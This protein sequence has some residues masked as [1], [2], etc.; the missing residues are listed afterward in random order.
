MIIDRPQI[1]EGSVIVNATVAMGNTAA[2][3]VLEANIGELFFNTD[4]DTLHAYNGTAWV[5]PGSVGLASHAADFSLHL[6]PAEHSLVSGITASATALNYTANL[7]SDAQGQLTTLSTASSSQAGTIS[8]LQTQITTNLGTA[9]A[10]QTELTTHVSTSNIHVTPAESS[11]LGSLTASATALNYTANLTSDAQGQLNTLTTNLSA[12]TSNAVIHLTSAESTLLGGIVG[13]STIAGL[14]YTANLSSD[15]QTQLRGKL[16]TTGGSMS[17]SIVFPNTSGVTITG[18]PTPVNQS[19][20][21]NMAYVV[22]MATGLHWLASAEVATTTNITLSGL[23]TID[24]YTTLVSDRV[25]VKNQTD[26]TTNGVYLA[27]TGAWTRSPDATSVSAINNSAIAV[28]NGTTQGNSTW[29]ESLTVVTVGTSPIQYTSFSG[30]VPFTAGT[31]ISISSGAISVKL[32]AGVNIDG[33]NNLIAATNSPFGITTVDALGAFSIAPGAYLSLV[34]QVGLTPGTYET[35]GTTIT[36]LVIDKYGRVTGT[37]ADVLIAPPFANIAS[38]PTT[39]DGYG[40]TDAIKTAGGQT[41]N[42][43]LSI[44]TG[45]PLTTYVLQVNGATVALPGS[46]ISQFNNDAGYITSAASGALAIVLV[47]GTSQSAVKGNQYVL[48]NTSGTTT[49]TLQA[50]PAN[51][52]TIGVLNLTGRT[53]PIVAHNGN[54]VMGLAQDLIMNELSV[55]I[56]L[57]FISSYGWYIM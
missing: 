57:R 52:D 25:L 49:I 54:N 47:S 56:T 16:N 39:V 55:N 22:A 36:P 48:T 8:N 51:G 33:S 35:G 1:E 24:G 37:G 23:Q 30:S 3:A 31:A 5:E 19:D 38:K 15:A 17:G 53:D 40:I 11:L 12:H 14:N 6:T 45:S 13:I 20:A 44:G 43:N 41:I 9:N 29:I 7:T 4:L 18:L 34:P 21:A 10:T 28:L 26:P 50:S 27:A 46:N 42:G 32:G 2:E